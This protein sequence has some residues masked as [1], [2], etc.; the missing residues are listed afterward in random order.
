[1]VFVSF[2]SVFFI[3][4]EQVLTIMKHCKGPLPII[5]GFKSHQST[6]ANPEM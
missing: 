2:Y 3:T 6:A 1:M 5:S 4:T